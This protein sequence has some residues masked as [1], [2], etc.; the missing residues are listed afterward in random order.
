MFNAVS[1]VLQTDSY[2]HGIS[3]PTLCSLVR[4]R[5]ATNLTSFCSPKMDSIHLM[6]DFSINIE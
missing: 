2:H 1:V 3:V 6:L 5:N 4:H